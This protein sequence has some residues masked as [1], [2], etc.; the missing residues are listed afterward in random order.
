MQDQEP[1][2]VED[3]AD[4]AMHVI[5]NG[6]VDDGKITIASQ[7]VDKLRE[8]IV[9]GQ[10][11]AGT[12]INLGAARNLFQ[13]SL[14][15]LREALA[16]LISDGLVTF[17]DNRGYRVAPMSSA[18]LEEITTLRLEFEIFALR[19]AIRLGDS[20]WE[21]EVIRVL[22]R[23]KKEHRDAKQPETLEAWEQ[24][25]RQFHLTLISGCGKPHLMNFCSVLL[26]LND[27]YRRTFLRATSG[28]RNV[29]FE[30]SEIAHAA[31]ARDVEYACLKLQDHIRRTG[32]NLLTHFA[33]NKGN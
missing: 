5:A 6:F 28:D 31:V 9:S 23:L 20:A 7:L 8:A 25:H 2:F 33:K 10:L 26:N 30:H 16:R 14:S 11:E 3:D 19:E 18:D 15:P 1:T 4:D 12:K 29:A 32:G 24:I 27:R 22:H 13:V 17:E 21:G